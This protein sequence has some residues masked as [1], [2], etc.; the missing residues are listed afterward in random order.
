MQNGVEVPSKKLEVE[1]PNYLLRQLLG[2]YL[3]KT[4]MPK[5]I[6]VPTMAQWEENPTA[7]VPIV[8]QW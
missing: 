1:L 2:I 7:E 6:G 3:E 8:A 5:D 4:I